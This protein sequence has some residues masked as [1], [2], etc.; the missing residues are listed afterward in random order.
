MFFACILPDEFSRSAATLFDDVNDDFCQ[1]ELI[2]NRFEKWRKDYA[3]SYN[4]AY[5]GLC[6]PKLFTP[7]VKVE[8][9]YW[10]PLEV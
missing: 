8:L 7:F 10:N 5:I 9:A 2:L 3:D 1:P 4:E 6:L